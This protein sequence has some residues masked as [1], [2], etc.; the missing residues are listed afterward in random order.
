[1]LLISFLLQF[2]LEITQNILCPES[3]FCVTKKKPLKDFIFFNQS[4]TFHLKLKKKKQVNNTKNKMI[5]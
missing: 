1:M 5:R 3:D 4:E 2:L